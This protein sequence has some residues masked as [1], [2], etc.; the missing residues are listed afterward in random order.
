VTIDE[1]TG[2]YHFL[3]NFYPCNVIYEGLTY[4]SSEH[5]YQAA[6]STDPDDRIYVK[7]A[8]DPSESK[9]RGRKID[10][11]PHWN[12]IK[13]LIMEDIV[14]VKFAQ[15]PELRKKLLATGDQKLEEGNDWGD[16]YWGTV[17]GEGSNMLGFILMRVRENLQ[18]EKPAGV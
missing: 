16:T 17:D 1:F 15:N 5:A 11:R 8:P 9:K 7:K 14:T 4:P 12:K 18:T 6:K 3:S 13:P 2:D 10:L